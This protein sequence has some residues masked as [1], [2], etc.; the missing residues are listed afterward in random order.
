MLHYTATRAHTPLKPM[1]TELF[2]PTPP[3]LGDSQSMLH[4]ALQSTCNGTGLQAIDVLWA[5]SSIPWL[6]VWWVW[7]DV[8]ISPPRK[9]IHA[10]RI[11]QK[12]AQAHSLCQP[13]ICLV[14]P[15]AADYTNLGCYAL[16]PDRPPLPNLLLDSP[17]MTLGVC[18][19]KAAAYKFFAL[20]NGT[21]CYA[22]NSLGSSLRH[23]RGSSGCTTRCSR[24]SKQTC[25]G[26]EAFMVYVNHAPVEPTSAQA[27]AALPSPSTPAVGTGP[28]PRSPPKLAPKPAMA[29]PAPKPLI[30][31]QVEKAIQGRFPGCLQCL[32]VSHTIC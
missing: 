16:R 4:V 28:V 24:S 32:A 29:R 23:G 13:G 12:C 31:L 15:A 8:L 6:L 5:V 17:K 19:R 22:A 21:R 26:P 3:P 27:P 7:L 14:A 9:H 18:Y 10:E 25:G 1:H 30:E 2:G 11:I 20:F